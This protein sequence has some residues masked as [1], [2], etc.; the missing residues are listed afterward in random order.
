[1]KRGDIYWVALPDQL[2]TEQHGQRPSAII[3]ANQLIGRTST[4]III[5]FT[6]N[7]RHAK[8]PTCL[9]I[10]QGQANLPQNSVALVHQIRAIDKQRVKSYIGS[11]DPGY[12]RTLDEVVRE[13]LGIS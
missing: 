13:I 5:P 12:L 6:T 4:I 9:F 8:D 1:M 2:G 10:P 7:L 11:L 3:Y